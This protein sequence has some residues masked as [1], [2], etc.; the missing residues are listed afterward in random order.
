[1][2]T[3]QQTTPQERIA[4]MKARTKA[5]KDA[6]EAEREKARNLCA[7]LKE[8][9]EALLA[10]LETLAGIPV[11]FLAPSGK[12]IRDSARAALGTR[13]TKENEASHKLWVEI[14]G[15]N[16]RLITFVVRLDG[17]TEEVSILHDDEPI[18]A[19][20]ALDLATAVVERHFDA[21]GES[22]EEDREIPF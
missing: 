14:T 18:T 7:K 6:L 17:D 4:A 19:E 13:D 22:P 9:A 16:I 11:S 15:T 1:M 2:K 8:E 10:S 3:T 12:L 5:V 20:I 21:G